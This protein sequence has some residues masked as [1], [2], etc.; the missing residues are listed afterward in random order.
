[1]YNN[2]LFIVLVPVDVIFLIRFS[3][4]NYS[5]RVSWPSELPPKNR[6]PQTTAH[7]H[8]PWWLPLI[9]LGAHFS[10]AAMRGELGPKVACI[11]AAETGV[12]G[13]RLDSR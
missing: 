11:L 2:I 9:K 13:S 3:V 12:R 6:S 5:K 4:K 10:R 8:V 7:E 1:M